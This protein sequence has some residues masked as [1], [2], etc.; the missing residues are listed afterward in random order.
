MKLYQICYDLRAPGRNYESLHEAIRSYG[1]WAHPL[2]STWIVRTM[3]SAQQVA[4]FLLRHMDPN[5]G[6]L[7]TRWQ[8]EGAWVNVNTEASE[9]M[10]QAA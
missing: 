1:N 9:W 7:V 4:E 8:G 10:K 5:D 3:Q 2:E 6:L